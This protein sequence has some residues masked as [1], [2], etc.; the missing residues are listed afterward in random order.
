M[1]KSGAD[2]DTRQFLQRL[3][4]ADDRVRDAA[5]K[6]LRQNGLHLEGEAKQ[7]APLKEGTLSGSGI[8]TRARW[9]GNT[10]ETTVGF[11]APYAAEVHETMVPAVD[12][13]KQPGPDT[14]NKPPTRFGPAGGKYLERP[15]R[16]M[17][18]EYT[19]RLA[20]AIKRR[21]R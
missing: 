12:A 20:V 1:G 19:K 18:T 7:L 3:D 21:L 11:N 9:K 17:M 8:T 2:L 14:R 5:L 15:M 10:A 16:G 13:K 6:Q 4:L